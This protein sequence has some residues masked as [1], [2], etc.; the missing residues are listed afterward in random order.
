MENLWGFWYGMEPRDAE[1]VLRITRIERALAENLSERELG[2]AYADAASRHFRQQISRGA[3]NALD[4]RQSQRIRRER[5]TTPH[6]L[7][8]KARTITIYGAA[9]NCDR[10]SCSGGE[11]TLKF[12]IEG[13]GFG[14]ILATQE[15]PPNPALQDLLT[16]MKERSARPLSAYSREWKFSPQTMVDIPSTNAS[17]SARLE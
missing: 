2:A 15:N 5:R 11:A 13:L 1:T 16:F 3:T 8:A 14:A 6:P 17:R 12:S 7:T 9:K 4:H 10:Q